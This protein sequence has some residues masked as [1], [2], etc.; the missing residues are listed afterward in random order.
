M[1]TGLETKTLILSRLMEIT[2]KAQPR[3]GKGKGPARRARAAGLVPAVVYGSTVDPI[4]LLLDAREMWH[5]L[6]TEAGSN[7]L[8][9]LE[10]DTGARLLTIPREIQK[11]P[12]K[13][14]LL[15]VDL[16]NVDRD[17][18][19]TADVPV[20]LFGESRGVK[21]GGQIDHH[22]HELKVEARPTDIPSAIEV[23]VSDLG[24]GDSVRVSD[25]ATLPGVVILNDPDD[26]IVAVIETIL[27]K[28]EEEV[29]EEAV[30]PEGEAPPS[31]EQPAQESAE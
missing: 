4:P 2:L 15:H 19:I 11:H 17:E 26:L 24:I 29:P 31:E 8:I 13:G 21:E 7:V 27:M 14:T 25:I 18:T 3:T 10:T 16:L 6:H 1:G 22:F 9:N 5:A 23:D 30:V 20:H 12:V 28:V